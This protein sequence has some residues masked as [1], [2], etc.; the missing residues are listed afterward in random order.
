MKKLFIVVAFI[1]ISCV[2]I[3]S[4]F[5]Y[6]NSFDYICRTSNIEFEDLLNVRLEGS[7]VLVFYKETFGNGTE[8]LGFCSFS[9]E[10]YGWK[11]NCQGAGSCN[12]RIYMEIYFL[13]A[14]RTIIFGLINDPEISNIKVINNNKDLG[15]A[16]IMKT[17]WKDIWIKY[18]DV[19][20][21]HIE[22]YN[23]EGDK[24]YPE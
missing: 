18:T 9:K 13:D 4:T 19:G 20:K 17:K 7:K 21:V 2:A 23:K 1:L 11:K 3:F 22:G 10:V 8:G 15:F 24:V 14:K 6:L 12:E 16:E 5:K